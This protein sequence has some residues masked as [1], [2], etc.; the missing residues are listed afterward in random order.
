MKVLKPYLK[1]TKNHIQTIY[2]L[3]LFLCF[4]ILDEAPVAEFIV[5]D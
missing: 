1:K 2:E 4:R 5:P 3:Y